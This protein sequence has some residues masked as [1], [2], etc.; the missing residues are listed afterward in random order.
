MA[1][2]S[3]GALGRQEQVSVQEEF[4]TVDLILHSSSETRRVDAFAL[5]LIK[6]EKQA[7]IPSPGPR[8]P[9]P[10]PRILSPGSADLRN[11]IRTAIG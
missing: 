7:R 4:S 8:I 10:G 5:S 11:R 2:G 1:R 3:V 6:V 9:D